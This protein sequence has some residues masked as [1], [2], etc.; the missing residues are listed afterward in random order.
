MYI[1][2][3]QDVLLAQR[4]IRPYLSRTPV[5]SYPTINALIGTNVY[6]KDDWTPVK[7]G[8]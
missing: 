7:I 3:F 8:E 2:R 4:Q 6:I 1:P 5:Y